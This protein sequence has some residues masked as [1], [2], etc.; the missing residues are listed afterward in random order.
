MSPNIATLSDICSTCARSIMQGTSSG[1]VPSPR[2]SESLRSNDVPSDSEFSKFRDTLKQGPTRIAKLDQKIARTKAFLDA[3]YNDRDLVKANIADAK[4][5]S[6][7]VRRLPADI[8]HS[9]AF[10]TIPSPSE[11][12]STGPYWYDSLDTRKP[13]WILSQV[14]RNWRLTIVSSSALWSSISLRIRHNYN[15][16]VTSISRLIF[17]HTWAPSRK[18]MECTSPVIDW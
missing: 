2:I 6:T 16:P 5:L 8:L 18:V 7:L 3:L 13:L 4:V 9:I 15:D 14:C 12:M 11:I 10:E 17:I 1:D